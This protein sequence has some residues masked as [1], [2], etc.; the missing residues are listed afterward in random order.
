MTKVID[1]LLDKLDKVLKQERQ[2][3]PNEEVLY[4]SFM[5][6]RHSVRYCFRETGLTVEIYNPVLD[7]YLDWVATHCEKYAIGWGDVEVE[8][9]DKWDAHGFANESDYLQYRYG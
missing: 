1:K 7:T 6:G 4:G 8:I 9:S 5:F 2:D 3:N